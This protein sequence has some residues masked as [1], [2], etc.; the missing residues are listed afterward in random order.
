MICKKCNRYL[1]TGENECPNCD[2]ERTWDDYKKYTST[3]SV[4]KDVFRDL[5]RKFQRIHL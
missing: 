3:W 4:I 5:G 2:I 1:R